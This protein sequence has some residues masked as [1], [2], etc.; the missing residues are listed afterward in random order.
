MKQIFLPVAYFFLALIISS[1]GGDAT[2][3][4]SDTDVSVSDSVVSRSD[5]ASSLVPCGLDPNEQ[6]IEI[7]LDCTHLGWFNHTCGPGSETI[8]IPHGR[9]IYALLVSG[10]AQN[11]NLD[12]F[13]WYNFA[14]CLHEKNAYVHYAWWNNLL[15]PYMQKPLHNPAST[16][17]THDNPRHDTEGQYN[18]FTWSWFNW[19]VLKIPGTENF[20]TKA[21]PAE[22]YQFQQDATILLKEIHRYN[23]EA[24]IILVGHSMGGDAIVRLATNPELKDT[25]GNLIDIDLLAP[26]DPVGNRTC[27]PTSPTNSLTHCNGDWHF[28]RY[29][30]VRKDFSFDASLREI[31]PNIKYLYHRFQKEWFPPYWDYKQTHLFNFPDVTH[32]TSINE[33]SRDD[34][35][36]NVQSEA[37]M[38]PR[39]GEDV[40][41]S[42]SPIPNLLGGLDGHGE[43]VGFRGVRLELFNN[44]EWLFMLQS[45]HALALDAQNNWPSR[46]DVTDF[47]WWLRVIH[48]RNW[49]AKSDYLDPPKDKPDMDYMAP[50][51]PPPEY[52]DHPDRKNHIPVGGVDEDYCTYCMVSGDLCTILKT[53]L[54]LPENLAP[55]ANANGPYQAECGGTTTSISLDGTGS[56]DPEGAS[57][58]YL[59]NT[60]CP[61]WGFD[62]PFSATPAL[63]VNTL[64]SCAVEC[65]VELTVTDDI[66]REGHTETSVSIAM[67]GDIDADNDVDT[68]DIALITAARNQPAD[69]PDDPRD[70]DGDGLITVL[71]ARRAVLLCTHPRCAT[72]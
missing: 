72:S 28:R 65:V 9:P 27:K 16:P 34:I 70:L 68:D 56:I 53:K 59:W 31:G 13:H 35:N 44:T 30:T 2:N 21:I 57:L 11:K 66:G 1:C 40:P 15:A 37:G 67:P 20:P 32:V 33:T 6:C 26:I 19:N 62:D 23:P 14:R 22:D 58:A 64:N 55:L 29:P 52:C 7:T 41:S 61:G 38:N 24:A 69:G 45:S 8:Q 4:P 12:M 50:L 42:L 39:S 17:S 71:D 47:D 18:W 48:M 43:I 54:D 46:D 10:F 51:V 5:S 25:D 3:S 49:E 36:S 63:T 60:D